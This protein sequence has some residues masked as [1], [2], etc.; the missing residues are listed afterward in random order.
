MKDELALVLVGGSLKLLRQMTL[1][2]EAYLAK[3][4]CDRQIRSQQHQLCPF[5]RC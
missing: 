1:T 5:H 4:I 2:G 3:A